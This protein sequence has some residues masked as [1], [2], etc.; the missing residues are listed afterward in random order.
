MHPL[1]R[2]LVVLTATLAACAGPA[3]HNAR[4]GDAMTTRTGG[5]HKPP[6]DL[7]PLESELVSIHGEAQRERIVRGLRQVAA[8]WRE[9]DG[10]LG[11]RRGERASAPR[12]T[13]ARDVRARHPRGGGSLP[14]EDRIRG[15]AQLADH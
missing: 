7:A 4:S 13:A 6:L 10:D 11:N 1:P 9:D 3:P 14:G 12:R 8:Q 2:S 15:A 5:S